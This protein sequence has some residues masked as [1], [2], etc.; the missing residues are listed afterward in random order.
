[1]QPLMFRDLLAIAQLVLLN[2]RQEHVELVSLL[3][4]FRRSPAG[5]NRCECGAMIFVSTNGPNVHCCSIKLEGSR[6]RNLLAT[7]ALFNL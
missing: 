4:S 3:G 7:L 2:E 5:L 1:M 6:F